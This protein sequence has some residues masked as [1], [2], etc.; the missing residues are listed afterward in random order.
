VYKE[1][2]VNLKCEHLEANGKLCSHCDVTSAE[3]NT[4][5]CVRWNEIPSRN[6]I[7]RHIFGVFA[8]YVSCV[9]TVR[10]KTIT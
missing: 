8:V 5:S 10:V 3:S 6:L 7:T 1:R 2:K 9:C 4:V